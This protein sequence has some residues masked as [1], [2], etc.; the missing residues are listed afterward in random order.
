MGEGGRGRC[1]RLGVPESWFWAREDP[2]AVSEVD[3]RDGRDAKV[4]LIG[5]QKREERKGSLAH[6]EKSRTSSWIS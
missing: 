3:E 2:G 6:I 5:G 4:E 1:S